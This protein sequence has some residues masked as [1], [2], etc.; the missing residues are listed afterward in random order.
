MRRKDIKENLSQTTFKTHPFK[1]QIRVQ[2]TKSWYC[3]FLKLKV[4]TPWCCNNLNGQSL[5]FVD[6]CKAQMKGARNEL[7]MLNHPVKEHTHQ[8]EL[9]KK[10]H[11]IPIIRRTQESVEDKQLISELAKSFRWHQGMDKWDQGDKVQRGRTTGHESHGSG[12]THRRKAE[13]RKH[14]RRNQSRSWTQCFL[15]RN[16]RILTQDYTQRRT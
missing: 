7:Q 3:F 9:F 8:K 2:P 13:G 15:S 16:A 14:S 1:F 4:P 10:I 6:L 12:K 5:W 11:D